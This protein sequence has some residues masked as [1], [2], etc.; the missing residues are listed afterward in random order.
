M[1]QMKK[2]IVECFLDAY[3]SFLY[4]WKHSKTLDKQMVLVGSF[5]KEGSSP[6]FHCSLRDLQLT[7]LCLD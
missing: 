2:H 4:D 7:M 3:N 6:W 1:E 5:L